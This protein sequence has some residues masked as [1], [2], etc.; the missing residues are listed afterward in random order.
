[1]SNMSRIWSRTALA[2]VGAAVMLSLPGAAFANHAV[3]VEGEEDFDGDNLVGLAE[4]NDGDVVFG[5]ITR[6]LGAAPALGQNGTAF[7]VTSGRFVE[8]VSISGAGQV[9]L[10]GAPGVIASVEAFVVAADRRIAE[11]PVAQADPFLLQGRA[12]IVI[13]SPNDRYVVI[14]NIATVNWTDGV[15]INGASHVLLDNVRAEHNINNGV[16]VQGTARV[17]II[18]SRVNSTG[19][20]LN[21]RT[22]NFPT[23]NQPNPGIGISFLGSSRGEIRF[24]AIT[25]NF[26]NGVRSVRGTRVEVDDSLLFDNER[27]DDLPDA[28]P[29][30]PATPAPTTPTT[31]TTPAP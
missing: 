24:S 19:F 25:G 10:E 16:L 29:P 5:T 2:A 11:F 1:M 8:Q 14:R 3:L 7:I 31:P 12:G 18:H 26:G 30:P 22:G 4:D 9:T 23:A 21:P 28:P 27:D 17:A 13:D 6:A 20:R 15:R